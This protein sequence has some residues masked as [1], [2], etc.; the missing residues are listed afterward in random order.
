MEKCDDPVGAAPQAQ[1]QPLQAS[2]GVK[3][4]T[5]PE[6]QEPTVAAL[7]A[8]AEQGAT[9]TETQTAETQAAETQTVEPQP[10]DLAPA[11][12]EHPR[13]TLPD[14]IE[15]VIDALQA[16]ADGAAAEISRD[17]VSRLRLHASTLRSRHVEELRA[18]WVA[19]GNA[20]EA[21]IA[22]EDDTE[23]RITAL[24]EAIRVKK[25]EYLAQQEAIRLANLERKN[26]I[27]EKI[28]ALADDTDNVGRNFP[29]Y[30]E[31]QDAFNAVGDVPPTDETAVWKRYQEA[32]E[33]YS[34]NLKINK[35]LRDYDFKKNL[36]S[37]ELLIKEAEALAD[38][39]DIIVA[40]KR[41]QSLHSKWREIGPVAKD[42]RE[43]IWGKFKEACAVVNKRYQAFFEERK[44][45][46]AENEAGKT[47]LCERIEALDF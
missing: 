39:P 16:L 34:D 44:A 4:T 23:S 30:R 31:L 2:E 5:A 46:E 37:K 26:D 15:G 42:L 25:N 28:N 22:P 12:P 11:E 38:E 43:E 7:S 33:R 40:F 17:V 19:E 24:I 41:V 35:E 13:H 9:T 3:E 32:R 10:A 1:D 6:A 18:A 21:F 29:A 27:I 14:T 45:R 20:P 8:D 36:E 47:A